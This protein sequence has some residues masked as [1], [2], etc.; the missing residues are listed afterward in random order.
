MAMQEG[1]K[2]WVESLMTDAEYKATAKKFPEMFKRD[3][4]YPIF[5]CEVKWR[6][7]MGE[8]Y[9]SDEIKSIN[10]RLDDVKRRANIKTNEKK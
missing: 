10:T 4:K 5:E 3:T 8:G 9:T 6:Y 7:K 1:E 2:I